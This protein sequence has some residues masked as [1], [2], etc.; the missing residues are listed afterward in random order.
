MVDLGLRPDFGTE[1]LDD[2]EQAK[3]GRNSEERSLLRSKY[4]K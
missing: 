3:A 1:F 4:L 2:V